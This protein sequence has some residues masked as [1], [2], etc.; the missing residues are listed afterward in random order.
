MNLSHTSHFLKTWRDTANPA[1]WR[2]QS[3]EFIFAG[4]ATPTS[5]AGAAPA[6][7]GNVLK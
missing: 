3:H 2:T 5:P 6:K 7:S 1:G 4:G